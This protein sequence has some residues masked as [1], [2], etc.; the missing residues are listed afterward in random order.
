MHYSSACTD[1]GE[2]YNNCYAPEININELITIS[3]SHVTRARDNRSFCADFF[4]GK[5]VIAKL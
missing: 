3:L 4:W 2:V 1:W 5:I